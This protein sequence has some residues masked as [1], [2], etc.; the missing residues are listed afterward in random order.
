MQFQTIDEAVSRSGYNVM[1]YSESGYGK[2]F[3][4]STLPDLSKVVIIAAE[5]G[6][7]TLTDNDL[8][9]DMSKLRVLTATSY[10]ELNDACKLIRDNLELID[11]VV[12]DSL[13]KVAERVLLSER[14]ITTD[15]R[16]LYPEI[17][18][19]VLSLLT[20]ML[21]MDVNLL[22]LCKQG[23]VGIAGL[24]KYAAIFPGQKLPQNIPYEF[25]YVFALIQKEDD[26]G[27]LKRAFQTQPDGMYHAK[28]R[29]SKLS[30]YESPNWTNIFN[31]LNA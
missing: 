31:K 8:D 5:K 12:I 24:E 7:K 11:T 23:K 4:I 14:E 13:T 19:K 25:D 9:I 2:T 15:A 20:R 29:G 26:P 27:T 6:L 1:L 21:D 17:E 16:K 10:N 30:M 28:T 18:A 3:S 22:C